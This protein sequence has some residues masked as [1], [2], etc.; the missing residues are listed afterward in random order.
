MYGL[1]KLKSSYFH[2]HQNN[3]KKKSQQKVVGVCWIPNTNKMITRIILTKNHSKINIRFG[4]LQP[5]QNRKSFITTP[6][7]HKFL[8]DCFPN[9]IQLT[10][11]LKIK[12]ASSGWVDSGLSFGE[13][14]VVNHSQRIDVLLVIPLKFQLHLDQNSHFKSLID[15]L[16]CCC[17]WL[18]I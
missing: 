10:I 3:H 16:E 13:S 17:C 4:N 1:S 2:N 11:N 8:W 7:S 6:T 9:I 5:T 15:T 12:V 14:C 18:G